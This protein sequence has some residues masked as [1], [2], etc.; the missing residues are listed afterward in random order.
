MILEALREGRT[1]TVGMGRADDRYF[2]FCAGLGIDAEVV[3]RV[4]QSR[5]RGKISKPTLYVRHVLAQY[6]KDAIGPNRAVPSLTLERPGEAPRGRPLLGT[7]PEHRAVD[8]PR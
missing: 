3:E 4:E 8:L 2:T 6:F 1:R 7:G 5:K